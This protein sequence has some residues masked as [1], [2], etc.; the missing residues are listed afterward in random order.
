MA[1]YSLAGHALHQLINNSVLY[2]LPV[3]SEVNQDETR[4]YFGHQKDG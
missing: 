1:S 3:L 2:L 4:E